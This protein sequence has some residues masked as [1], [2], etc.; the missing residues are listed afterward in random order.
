MIDP[1]DIA[2]GVAVL[3]AGVGTALGLRKHDTAKKEA[4]ATA[5]HELGNRYAK[6]AWAYGRAHVEAGDPAK[7]Q[8]HVEDAFLLID[9]TA[10]G[11]RDFTNA[12][13]K[14]YIEANK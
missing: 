11:K 12:Q 6:M 7:L 14:I 13:A 10:D 1:H 8:K 4:E 2:S 9:T 5:L 3:L